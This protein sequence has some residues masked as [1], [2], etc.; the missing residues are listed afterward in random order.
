[1][2]QNQDSSDHYSLEAASRNTVSGNTSTRIIEN[3]IFVI[4][5]VSTDIDENLVGNLQ[6]KHEYKLSA[7]ESKDIMDYVQEKTDENDDISYVRSYPHV[8][9]A[10]EINPNADAI[11]GFSLT[12]LDDDV[13]ENGVLSAQ[14]SITPNTEYLNTRYDERQYS[15]TLTLME[16]DENGEWKQVAFPQG[17]VFTSNGKILKA[18]EE[19]KTVAV[20]ASTATDSVVTID[21]H[22]DGFEEGKQY[23]LNA[24]LYSAPDASYYN[25]LSTTHEAS[26][27]FVVKKNVAHSIKVSS[28]TDS[29]AWR[30]LKQTGSFAG[31]I[32]VKDESA[33]GNYNKVSVNLYKQSGNA[34]SSVAMA[35]VFENAEITGSNFTWSVSEYAPQGVYRLE[36]I[37]FDKAEYLDVIV[38]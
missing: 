1:M 25:D 5:F 27:E 30:V 2:N 26:V 38:K 12:L 24:V 36:F 35:T 33:E 19:N 13:Y 8:S 16:K 11:Q 4:D 34:F 32:Q 20:P 17:A 9:S 3:L 14:I 10:F 15:A 37:Y 7:N 31:T 21:T 23:K 28:N 18:A 22:L 29:S 6:L